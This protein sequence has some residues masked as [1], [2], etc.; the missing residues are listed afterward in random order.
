MRKQSDDA[1]KRSQL[2]KIISPLIASRSPLIYQRSPIMP[3]SDS[4][5][6]E[7]D[8]LANFSLTFRKLSEDKKLES[9]KEKE[10]EKEAALPSPRKEDLKSSVKKD[11]EKELALI[12]PPERSAEKKEVEKEPERREVTI[13]KKTE[14]LKVKPANMIV[15][16]QEDSDS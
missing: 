8:E 6:R 15:V 11:E 2:E 13:E 1:E 16:E 7:K 9:K 5:P 4:K 10:K 3:L 14:A 12:D